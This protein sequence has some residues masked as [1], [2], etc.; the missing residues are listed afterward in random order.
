VLVSIGVYR[1]MRTRPV[2]AMS[3]WTRPMWMNLQQRQPGD[4][5]T[6]QTVESQGGRLG[7]LQ[8]IARPSFPSD[9]RRRP[10]RAMRYALGPG[11]APGSAIGTVLSMV[12]MPALVLLLWTPLLLRSQSPA[13]P[14]ILANVMANLS[15]VKFL[16][17]LWLW[18][19]HGNLGL[20]ESALLPGLGAPGQANKLFNQMILKCALAAMLPWL[21]LSCLLGMVNHAPPAYYP[22]VVSITMTATLTASALLLACMR[23]PRGGLVLSIAQFVLAMLGALSIGQ[24]GLAGAVAP[25]WL[26]PAWSLLLAGAAVAYAMTV[27]RAGKRPHPW[28]LN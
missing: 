21:G 27:R 3:V 24:V 4:G 1:H 11:F 15:S 2:D 13:L 8:G 9:V 18:R 23:W 14:L 25:H 16:Q 20:M 22:L 19:K 5:A 17:R 6:K 12:A 10:E 7:W 28:L 26:A